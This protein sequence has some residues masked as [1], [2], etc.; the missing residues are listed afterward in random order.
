VSPD[1]AHLYVA[2]DDDNAVATFAR[3]ATSG[4]LSF[5]EQDMDGIGGVDGID[6]AWGVAASPDPAGAHVYVTG[7]EEDAMATF[8]REGLPVDAGDGAAADADPPE[9]TIVKGP[10]KKTRKR[11]AKFKFA[12]DEPGS[13]FECKLDNKDFEPCDASEKFKVKRRKHKLRVA[14]VDQAGNVDPTPAK[15]KWKVKE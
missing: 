13:T 3:D 6:G 9:T 5:V 10:N 12:S 8:S 2:G 4:A 7:D 14:A 15:R 11:K 1:G